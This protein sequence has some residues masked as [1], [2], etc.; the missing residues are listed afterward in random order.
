M[1]TISLVSQKGG[2]G[3]TLLSV[4]L[5]AYA[6]KIGET[7]AIIDIDSQASSCVWHD[8]RDATAG[9]PEISVVSCQT[10]RLGKVLDAAKDEGASLVIID[11]SP[12]SEGSTLEA[13]KRSDYALIPCRPSLADI[14]AIKSTVDLVKI[15]NVPA[16]IVINSA[17]NEGLGRDAKKAVKVYGLPIASVVVGDRTP[18]NH[19]F[20]CGLG[21]WEYEPKSKAANEIRRLYNWISK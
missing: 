17:K 5:A 21:I 10:R 20:T 3:K 7:V 13:A 9:L 12:N 2:A 16:G 14:R 11:T 19:A 18:F 4:N 6:A 1:R 15:A 8:E